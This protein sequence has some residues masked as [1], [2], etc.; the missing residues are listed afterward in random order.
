MRPS[1]GRLVGAVLGVIV[2]VWVR[3]LRVRVE[4]HTESDDGRSRRVLAFFH[5]HQMA[6]LGAE[7]RRTAVLVS[8]SADGE[9]Q[10]AV[11]RRLGFSVARGS[12]SRGGASGLRAMVR[13][14]EKGDDAAFAVDGPRGPRGVAKS[15]VFVAAR[16]IGAA[17]LPVASAAERA[18]VL[19]KAWDRFEIPWPFSRVAVVVGAPLGPRNADPAGLGAAI[20]DARAR[21]ESLLALAARRPERI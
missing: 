4:W 9:V 8:R 13:R 6:L 19:A 16:A 2:A 17:I 21:A 18:I 15:G 11:M 20:R 1:L 3:T 14:L 12:S 7:R 5:G 10:A